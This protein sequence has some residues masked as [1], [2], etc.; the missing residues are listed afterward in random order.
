MTGAGDQNRATD[1]LL[2]RFLDG[3]ACSAEEQ[4]RIEGDPQLRAR[5]AELRRLG[6]IMRRLFAEGSA[7][8]RNRPDPAALIAY[9]DGTL[10]EHRRALIEQRVAEDT[11]LRVEID[12][13]RKMGE[14]LM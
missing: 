8:A 7:P 2:Q 4:A 1:A 11:E 14:G 3:G 13:L 5:A 9:I 12:L 6:A 10:D